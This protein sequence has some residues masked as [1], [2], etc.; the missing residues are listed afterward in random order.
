MTGVYQINS[1]FTVFSPIEILEQNAEYL[2]VKKGT[3]NGVA[4]YD[5]LL[6]NAS[7]YT[8]GQILH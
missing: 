4:T 2:L 1:G 5:T 7:A 8:A 6:L 3:Q